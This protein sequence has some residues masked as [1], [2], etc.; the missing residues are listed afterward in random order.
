[1]RGPLLSS[2]LCSSADGSPSAFKL[3]AA[4]RQLLLSVR[5]LG[6]ALRKT[7]QTPLPIALAA[8]AV[9]EEIQ[10]DGA[11]SRMTQFGC[12]GET[13]G[14]LR[15]IALVY[16]CRSCTRRRAPPRRRPFRRLPLRQHFRGG[17]RL[18]RVGKLISLANRIY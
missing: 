18:S 17:E 11:G 10:V 4:I 7:S 6:S 2:S 14:G 16:V 3:I 5:V 9:G 12:A 8:R 1:M 15:E 13:L